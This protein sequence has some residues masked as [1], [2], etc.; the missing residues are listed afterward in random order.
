MLDYRLKSEVDSVHS[1]VGSIVELKAVGLVPI[2]LQ[3]S[4]IYREF[5]LVPKPGIALA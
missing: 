2:T 4:D 5:S 1:A 3:A